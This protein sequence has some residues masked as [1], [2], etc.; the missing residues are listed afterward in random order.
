MSLLSLNYFNVRLNYIKSIK[1][2]NL[3]DNIKYYIQYF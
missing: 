2:K 1:V 3:A